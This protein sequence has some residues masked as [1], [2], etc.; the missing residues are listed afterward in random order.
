[1]NN[2][3][4]ASRKSPTSAQVIAERKAEAARLMAKL[5][6]M[7]NGTPDGGDWCHA[8]DLGRIVEGLKELTLE[9]G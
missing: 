9:V 6:A 1:M 3:H 2:A 7:V 8:G 4:T 5:A